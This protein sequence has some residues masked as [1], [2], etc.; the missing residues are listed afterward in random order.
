MPTVSKPFFSAAEFC[1]GGSCSNQAGP[2]HCRPAIKNTARSTSLGSD[3]AHSAQDEYEAPMNQLMVVTRHWL[4]RFCRTF[5]RLWS[6]TVHTSAGAKGKKMAGTAQ[7]HPTTSD[8]KQWRSNQPR[9]RS[10]LI[11]P[12]IQGTYPQHSRFINL[13]Y[14]QDTLHAVLVKSCRNCQ[15][16]FCS[17][18]SSRAR[19]A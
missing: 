11:E 15:D 4:A 10:F 5:P 13:A 17:R 3:F 19:K 12:S 6:A 14:L 1:R 7:P 9:H 2:A 16:R 8:P 18:A